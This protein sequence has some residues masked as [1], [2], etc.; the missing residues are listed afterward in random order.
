MRTKSIC[1]EESMKPRA[2][3]ISDSQ[4]FTIAHC[5]GFLASDVTLLL[6]SVSH[7]FALRPCMGNLV[8]KALQ[9]MRHVDNS[10]K[11][12]NSH[13]SSWHG[14][15]NHWTTTIGVKWGSMWMMSIHASVSISRWK[16]QLG[17][18]HKVVLG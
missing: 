12:W 8:V 18:P 1:R 15:S 9:S 11:K 13:T 2:L 16:Y 3:R 10:P 14:F 5:S 4:Q 7:R 6:C 17:R